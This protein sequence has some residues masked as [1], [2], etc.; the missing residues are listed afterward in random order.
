[1]EKPASKPELPVSASDTLGLLE[2]DRRNHLRELDELRLELMQQA[3]TDAEEADPVL[4]EKA[5]NMALLQQIEEH[6]AEIDHALEAAKEGR[7]GV[8]ERC[9]QP[10]DPERLRILPE[11]RLCIRCK[12]Q[13]EKATHRHQRR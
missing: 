7:Y 6:V 1:M 3:E 8:C 10:I 4:P 9:H 5:R 11:T 13:V 2:G 12:S